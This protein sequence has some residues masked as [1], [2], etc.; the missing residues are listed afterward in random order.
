M[1]ETLALILTVTAGVALYHFLE[2]GYYKISDEIYFHK[3]KEDP[4]HFLNFAKLFDEEVKTVKKKTTAK[5][6]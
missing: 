1:N 5:K 3:R 4:N 2:W 6:K